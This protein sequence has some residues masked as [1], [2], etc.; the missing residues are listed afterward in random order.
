MDDEDSL[1]NMP[2]SFKSAADEEL[3]SLIFPR[4]IYQQ[5]GIET[6]VL[7]TL[8]EHLSRR[9]DIASR[10]LL[11]FMTASCGYPE[12]RSLAAQRLEMWL[13]SPK[14]GTHHSNTGWPIAI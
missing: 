6:T 7:D 1:S 8:R 3:D 12:V 5:V 13:Q 10:N 2:G 4:Y 14:V 9:T 11:R